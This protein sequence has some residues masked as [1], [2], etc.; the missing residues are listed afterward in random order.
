M[1]SR[2]NFILHTISCRLICMSHCDVSVQCSQEVLGPDAVGPGQV[3]AINGPIQIGHVT[4]VACY[5]ASACKRCCTGSVRLEDLLL[6]NCLESIWEC[7]KLSRGEYLDVH[8]QPSHGS[9]QL[10]AMSGTC[11]ASGAKAGR[12]Y[13]WQRW[14]AVSHVIQCVRT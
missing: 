6:S 2:Q 8:T 13:H 1:G 4:S 14:G 12:A 5:G 3:V 11:L 7:G 10:F 9:E